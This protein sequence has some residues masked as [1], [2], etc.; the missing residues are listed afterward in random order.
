MLKTLYKLILFFTFFVLI[1]ISIPYLVESHRDAKKW[2]YLYNID[3]DIDLLIMGSSHIFT[4]LDPK[5]LDKEL[6][7]NSFN[8]GSNGQII[9]QTYYN[10]IEILKYRKPK[11]II[12]DVNCFL[13][14]RTLP[15]MYGAI[16]HGQLYQNLS[17]MKFS[18]NK[19][20][21]FLN[22][23]NK[24]EYIDAIPLFIKE[25]FN[26][27]RFRKPLNTYNSYGYDQ[28]VQTKGF[29]AKKSNLTIEEYENFIA[30]RVLTGIQFNPIPESLSYLDKIVNLCK[31][32]NIELILLKTPTL[33]P[34]DI[35]ISLNKFLNN[36][37]DKN[38]V[39]LYNLG[40]KFDEIEL[41]YT[42]YHDPSHIS[43]L[44]AQK[45]SLYLSKVLLKDLDYIIR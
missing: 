38:K 45:I 6:K 20:Y 42:D 2:D 29:V 28:M 19:I 43:E 16:N 26:W 17:G 22:T 15:N 27:K 5:V 13:R 33:R 11:I 24:D 44:G 14:S 23:I 3:I 7:I 41:I 39:N 36:Y 21:S 18:I 31:I 9:N 12:V 35:N 32:N 4:A 30:Q 8:S 34:T 1:W 10:L 25:K 37:A 40:K